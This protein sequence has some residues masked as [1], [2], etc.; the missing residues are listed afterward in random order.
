LHPESVTKIHTQAQNEKEVQ[1]NFNLGEEQIKSD[2]FLGAIKNRL[3]KAKRKN[4]KFNLHPK[5]VT[6]IHIQAQ[7]ER[8]AQTNFNLG[9]E[10]IKNEAFLGAIKNR[11]A[12]AKRTNETIQNLNFKQWTSLRNSILKET[13]IWKNCVKHREW[14]PNQIGPTFDCDEYGL[15]K[16]LEGTKQPTWVHNRRAFLKSLS[17]EERNVVLTG[18]PYTEFDPH[19]YILCYS[20]PEQVQQYPHIEEFFQHILPPVQVQDEF[21]P[22]PPS[23]GHSSGRSTPQSGASSSSG[24]SGPF[25]GFAAQ[26]PVLPRTPLNSDYTSDSNTS[27]GPTSGLGSSQKSETL[28]VKTKSP[29]LKKASEAKQFIQKVLRSGKVTTGEP[30]PPKPRSKVSRAS[31]TARRAGATVTPCPA[32]SGNSSGTSTGGKQTQK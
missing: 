10:Q 23:S 5:S 1:T 17:R 25:H 27:A 32:T 21:A 14:G 30:P 15:P 24:S 11:L 18:D 9:E 31:L 2:A 4:E 7:N 16:K 26:G 29:V 12:K 22:D 3:A 28:K 19:T 6:K 20:F 13:E 8:E